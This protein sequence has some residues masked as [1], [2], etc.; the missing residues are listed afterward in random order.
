MTKIIT[1]ITAGGNSIR[2]GENKLLFKI[3]NMTVIEKTI[4][5]FLDISDEIIIPTG[6][7]VK[8]YLQD[9]VSDKVKFVPF[10]NIRK[11]S[12]YNAL[13]I[14]KNCDIVLI[15]DG[16]RPFV[17]KEDIL[18]VINK[19]K[20]KGA[21]ILGTMAY[22]TIKTVQ[23]DKIETTLDRKKIFQAYTPQAFKFEIFDEI[24]SEYE[25][26]IDYTDDSAILEAKNIPC[27]I[28]IG[29]K[30]NIKITFKQDL[31]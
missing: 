15:H 8:N 4:S 26:D 5:K 6:D 11:K 28:V 18:N 25:N 23:D 17:E 20:E 31:I 19:T 2:F 9:K 22:D 1:I 12:V 24:K 14:I 3:D 7:E 21:A 10:G 16:A 30:N 29:K 27:Y 13:K